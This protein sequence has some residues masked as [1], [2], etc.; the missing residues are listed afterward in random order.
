[1]GLE[2]W[3]CC[4]CVKEGKA[5]PHPFPELLAFD[6]TGEATLK[7]DREISL[8]VWTTHDEWYRNSCPHFGQLIEKRLGNVALIAHVRGFLEDNSPNE[9]PLLLERVVYSGTHSGDWI[10]VRDIPRVMHEVKRLQSLTSDPS[11]VEFANA[12]AELAEAS[13]ATG[14]P[15]V[16]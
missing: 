1:M 5:P 3:V 14:N 13:T 12:L 10:P 15:I 2:A 6:E 8:Q 16:F 7:S 11:I 4:N 9:F